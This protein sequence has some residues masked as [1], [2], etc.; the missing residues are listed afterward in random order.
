MQ[1]SPHRTFALA[2]LVAA[3]FVP[4]AGATV[5]A[6]TVPTFPRPQVLELAL[7]AYRCAESRGEVSKPTLAVIDYSLPST[8]KRLW[9]LDTDTGAVLQQE[10]VAHGRESGE[11]MAERFSNEYESYQSSVG[12]FVGR[13]TYFGSHGLSLRLAGLEPGFNDHADGRAIVMHGAWYVS[14]DHISRW[15][16]LGR[17]LGC[18]AVAPEVTAR[19]IERLRGGAALFAY[20]DEPVWLERSPYLR[21]DAAALPKRLAASAERNAA[22]P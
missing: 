2:L 18:P 8:E 9:I 5:D 3:S 14:E 12:F 22:T 4:P 7:R 1:A 10:L 21:C 19:V 16:R 17:S 20:A 11:L 13:D 6:E 15:G